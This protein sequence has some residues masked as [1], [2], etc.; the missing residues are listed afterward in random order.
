MLPGIVCTHMLDPSGCQGV[1]YSGG[2]RAH[3]IHLPAEAA[4]PRQGRWAADPKPSFL[5]PPAPGPLFAGP[6]GPLAEHKSAHMTLKGAPAHASTHTAW[7]RAPG[8]AVSADR[9]DH[10]TLLSPAAGPPFVFLCLGFSAHKGRG[11]DRV[12]S[13]VLT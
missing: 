3:Q 6:A 11:L 1:G 7:T 9:E 4:A 8:T 10:R 12:L 2:Q 5:L 13:E